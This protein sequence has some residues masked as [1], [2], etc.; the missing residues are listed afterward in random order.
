MS[1]SGSLDARPRRLLRANGAILGRS[2][3]LV[4]DLVDARRPTSVERAAGSPRRRSWMTE[5]DLP[6]GGAG[7]SAVRAEAVGPAID[8]VSRGMATDLASRTDLSTTLTS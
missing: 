7:T 8:T 2:S 3:G 4:S 5:P 1:E 6:F